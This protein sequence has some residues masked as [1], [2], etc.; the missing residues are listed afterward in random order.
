[1]GMPR[2][3]SWNPQRTR[4]VLLYQAI[5]FFRLRGTREKAARG[6]AIGLACNFYPT[7]GSGGIL[8]A[9]LARLSGGSL[10]AG[11]VGGT[12]LA[13]IW[14]LVFYI[15]IRTGALFFSPAIGI[16]DYEDI[17]E[18][19]NALLWGKTFAIS[20][21]V[22]SLVA[23]VISYLLFLL[24][25]ERVRTP[26]L[27]WLRERVRRRKDVTTGQRPKAAA[28]LARFPLEEKGELFAR[29]ARSNRERRDSMTRGT[30]CRG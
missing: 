16:D 6:F 1:M 5:R 20:A 15:N 8:G 28:S 27:K 22:N 21:V 26:A 25:F 14:P 19:M 11:F 29:H 12:T 10:V 24:M 30:V 13:F 2:M 3:F 18:S 9:F 4:D 23:I 17:T 7:F